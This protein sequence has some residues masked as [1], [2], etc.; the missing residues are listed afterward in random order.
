MKKAL[1][2]VLMASLATV[3]LAEIPVTLGFRGGASMAKLKIEDDPLADYAKFKPGALG[4]IFLNLG[5]YKNFV[6]LQPEVN[7]IQKGITYS[8]YPDGSNTVTMKSSYNYLSSVL[9]VFGGWGNDKFGVRAGIGPFYANWISGWPGNIKRKV[10]EEDGRVAINDQVKFDIKRG[11]DSYDN[12][13]EFGIA[14]GAGVSLYPGGGKHALVVDFR[15]D[16]GLTDT[17]YY[18]EGKPAGTPKGNNNVMS[19]SFGYGYRIQ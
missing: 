17:Y 4:G 18:V 13:H 9:M 3:T 16:L 15:Y 11:G 14:A 5:I 7:I 2:I 6:S 1:L 12:R 19:L 8:E 10:V